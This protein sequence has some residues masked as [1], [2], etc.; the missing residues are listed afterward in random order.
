MRSSSPTN[1]LSALG[2]DGNGGYIVKT[3]NYT[4]VAGDKIA[5]DTTGG[6]F[7][8]TLPAT[9]ADGDSVEIIPARGTFATN[10]LTVAR[11]GE[12]IDGAAANL[13]L[14]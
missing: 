5:A 14:T 8:V 10:N 2:I 6:A 4:A 9:P 3:A 1:A 11:N 12:N 13:I 7:T